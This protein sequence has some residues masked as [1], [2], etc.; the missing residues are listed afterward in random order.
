MTSQQKEPFDFMKVRNNNGQPMKDFISYPDA[1]RW[2]N[3]L[4]LENYRQWLKFA[5]M[6]YKKGPLRGRL[7]R[8]VFIPSNPQCSYKVRDEWVNDVDFLGHNTYWTYEQSQQFAMSLNLDSSYQWRD[9]HRENAPP[10]IPRYPEL[11]Y[12]EWTLWRDFIG[13]EYV[14]YSKR[15]PYASFEEALKVVHSIRFTTMEEYKDWIRSNPQYNLPRAP[16]AH[17]KEH[18]NGWDHFLGKSISNRIEVEQSINT[19]VLYIAHHKYHASNVYEIKIERR[20]KLEV[21]AIKARVGFNIIK[22]YAITPDAVDTTKRIVMANGSE[23]WETDNT[24]IIRNIHELLFQL[25]VLL[26]SL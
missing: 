15:Q 7:I 14:H 3:R 2:V 20:G 19:A 21:E 18:W 24:Y 4:G 1:K 16:D 5:K 17:Y 8:P 26:Y 10:H 25:D 11:V 22:M 6:R 12:N 13:S 23:W 9:W